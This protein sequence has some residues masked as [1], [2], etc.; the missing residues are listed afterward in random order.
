MWAEKGERILV[1][2]CY[3]SLGFGS[4]GVYIDSDVLFSM[5]DILK[6]ALWLGQLQIARQEEESASALPAALPLFFQRH[7]HFL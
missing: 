4:I 1:R 2:N 7:L 5:Q 6:S 3:L